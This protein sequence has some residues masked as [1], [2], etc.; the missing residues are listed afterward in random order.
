MP[1]NRVDTVGNRRLRCNMQ[2]EAQQE[3]YKNKV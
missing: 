1:D 3:Y 2:R